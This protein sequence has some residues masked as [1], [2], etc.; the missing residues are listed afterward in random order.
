MKLWAKIRPY[1]F[2]VVGIAALFLA[3][4]LASW[5]AGQC[6]GNREPVAPPVIPGHV[7]HGTTAPGP[8]GEVP[9]APETAEIAVPQLTRAQVLELAA[10]YGLV[11]TKKGTVTGHQ[12]PP[13]GTPGSAPTGDPSPGDRP[14]DANL[15]RFPR[16][17]GE[18]IFGPGPA[19]DY[20]RVSAWQ[21]EPGGRVDLRTI[22]EDYQPPATPAP[23][24]GWLGNE[25]RWEKIIAGGVVATPDG[26]G[27]G[28]MVGI[29]YR[30]FRTGKAI[31]GIDAVAT[32]AQIN[33]E[34]VGFGFVG[35]SVHF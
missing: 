6:R 20:A 30:G 28:P 13:T 18:E 12:P 29:G 16:L 21:L 35:A 3:V 31:W 11:L 23:K 10:K 7:D 8:V 1:L 2:S 15:D 19:G 27:Y 24:R 33:G 32:G 25:A 22:W 34:T 9:T 5:I 26:I 14:A 4:M 17:F